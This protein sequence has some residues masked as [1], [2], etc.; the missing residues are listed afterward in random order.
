MIDHP[1]LLDQIRADPPGTE[2]LLEEVEEGLPEIEQQE[3]AVN[4]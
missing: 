1:L 3:G 2:S 4:S